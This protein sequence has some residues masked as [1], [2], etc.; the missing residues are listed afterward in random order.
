MRLNIEYRIMMDLDTDNTINK[1]AKTSK[2]LND[3]A[4]FLRLIYFI[5]H[6]KYYLALLKFIYNY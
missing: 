4:S 5:F 3:L 6:I 2:M 1:V